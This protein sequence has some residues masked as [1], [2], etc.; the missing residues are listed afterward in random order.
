MDLKLL[1]IMCCPECGSDLRCLSEKLNERGGVIEGK[2]IC[3][4]CQIHYPIIKSIPRFVPAENYAT[5]FGFQWNLYKYTQVDAY[6]KINSSEARFFAETRWTQAE[7][8]DN[9][10]LEAGC[11]NGR[12][13]EVCSRMGGQVVGVDI[14]TAIDAAGELFKDRS[15]VHLVQASLYALPFKKAAFDKCYSIGVIQHT[16]DP[17]KSVRTL[18]SL[19]KKNGKLALTIYERKLWTPLYSKYWFR[20]LTKRMNKKLLLALIKLSSPILFPLTEVLFRI[21]LLNKFFKFVI[22]YANYVNMRE[23]SIKQRYEWAILDTFD[24]L[25]PAYD[26]PMTEA[27]VRS[28]LEEE[29]MRNI[30]RLPNPGVNLIAAK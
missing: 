18:P 9:W 27:E 28:G 19:I 15:N 8:K 6:S 12:F 3:D 23:L 17:K 14:S 22:P 5:S 11:G 24:M 30:T 2:L 29:K 10:I 4:G 13:I 25:S 7:M 26:L 21:P 1:D 16:P 20:P